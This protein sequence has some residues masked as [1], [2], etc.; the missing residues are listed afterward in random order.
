M[1]LRDTLNMLGIREEIDKVWSAIEHELNTKKIVISS[2]KT[3]VFKF[4][5]LLNS[6]D[7][8]KIYNLD[9]E[10]DIFNKE[11]L[12]GKFLDLYFEIEYA[13][14]NYRVGI[15]FKFPHKKKNNSGA[16]EI[17]QKIINDL[18]KLDSLIQ[19]DKID[20]GIFLC[21][22]NERYFLLNKKRT[23]SHFATYNNKKYLFDEFYP[24]NEKYKHKLKVSNEIMFYWRNQNLIK[25]DYFSFLDPIHII[26]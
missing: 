17:R 24:C 4:A 7:N 5:W 18:K 12:D 22:T 15:E 23:E 6:N 13:N 26:K 2:E 10:K 9:F 16:T 8:L 21:A 11:F 20:L 14:K 3:L 1:S 19:D 25:D